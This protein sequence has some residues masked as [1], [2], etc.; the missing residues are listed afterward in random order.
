MNSLVYDMR[1]MTPGEPPINHHD[2]FIVASGLDNR[3][4]SVLSKV[5]VSSANKTKV[6]LVHFRERL[7]NRA[8]DDHLFAFRKLKITNCQEVDCDIKDPSTSLAGL[9]ENDFDNSKSIGIDISCFT[10]PYF[11]FL[12]KLLQERY[13]VTAITAYYTEPKSYKFTKGLFTAF[14]SSAGPL[15][16]VEIPGY[17]GRESRDAIRKLI[18]LLGFDPDLSREINE[19]VSP[20]ETIVVNGFPS[21]SPKFK[22]ISLIANEKLV[23]AKNVRVEY[24]RANHPFEVYNLLEKL[25]REGTADGGSADVFLNIAPVGT[26]PMALGACLFALHNPEVRVVYPMPEEYED[27]Y[28]DASWNSWKYQLP[29]TL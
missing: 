6:I 4:Y 24:A 2:Y 19:D 21:Y 29:L 26:K 10:K 5:D 9:G 13:S 17:P 18:I 7:Q 1:L 14:H 28:S 23:S 25:K 16:I 12:I 20:S 15:S 3:A 11:Y 27:K 22:D 8:A